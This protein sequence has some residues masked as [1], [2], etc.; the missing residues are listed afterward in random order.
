M[1]RLR[2]ECWIAGYRLE[3]RKDLVQVDI[4][5]EIVVW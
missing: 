1:E 5:F 3:R 2:V 4:E